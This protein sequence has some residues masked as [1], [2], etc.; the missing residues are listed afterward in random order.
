VSSES[1]RADDDVW[2][3]VAIKVTHGLDPGIERR[4]VLH[5]NTLELERASF[6]WVEQNPGEAQKKAAQSS[7]DGRNQKSTVDNSDGADK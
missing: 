1:W 6:G 4:L 3:A 7:Q 5:N 2:L